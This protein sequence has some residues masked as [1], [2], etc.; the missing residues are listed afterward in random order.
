[1]CKVLIHKIF[2]S[3][4]PLLYSLDLYSQDTKAMAMSDS[5]FAVGVELY[6]QERYE[7]SAVIF[8]ELLGI[9]TL[10]W[11]EVR[12]QRMVYT[13]MWLGSALYKIGKE[14]EA[15][16]ETLTSLYYKADPVDHRNMLK[17]DSLST[18]ARA[19]IRN[20]E[21]DEAIRLFSE[22]RKIVDSVL[23]SDHIWAV[24]NRLELAKIYQLKID[25]ALEKDLEDFRK[26]VF[27][28]F[29]TKSAI[30]NAGMADSLYNVYI[31]G[32]SEYYGETSFPYIIC[33]VTSGD[34]YKR[35]KYSISN[36]WINNVEKGLNLLCRYY[37]QEESWI[38]Q[39]KYNLSEAL[40][41]YAE[42][43][44]NFEMDLLTVTRDE[45]RRKNL[46]LDSVYT[47]SA[48][49]AEDVL[50]IMKD[51]YPHDPFI[52]YVYSLLEKI[53]RNRVNIDGVNLFQDLNPQFYDTSADGLDVSQKEV[54]DMN[55][56][57]LAEL[58]AAALIGADSSSVN[59]WEDK[60]LSLIKDRLEW[61]EHED[62]DEKWEKIYFALEDIIE[63]QNKKKQFSDNILYVQKLM[64][65]DS[66]DLYELL[67]VF[68]LDIASE[69]YEKNGDLEKA[70]EYQIEYY[71]SL[72]YETDAGDKKKSL[73]KIISLGVQSN[74]AIAFFDLRHLLDEFKR[75]ENSPEVNFQK[76]EYDLLVTNLLDIYQKNKDSN[77]AQLIE[78]LLLKCIE[79]N[80]DDDKIPFFN[81]LVDFYESNNRKN[82]AVK[83]RYD[84]FA[85]KANRIRR[86]FLLAN[87]SL[88]NYLWRY[89]RSSMFDI[90][91][92]NMEDSLC[93]PLVY[94][95]ALLTK[96][97][98]L[99]QEM[100]IRE[101]FNKYKNED[102]E[103]AALFDQ[104]QD[105]FNRGE[106]NV[107]LERKLLSKVSKSEYN[108]FL[109][110]KWSDVLKNIKADEVAI[111]FV[112]FPPKIGDGTSRY[113]ASVI[114][115]TFEIPVVVYLFDSEELSEIK[116]YYSDKTLSLKI[117]GRISDYL[118]DVENIYFSADGE[119]HNI[120]IEQLPNWNTIGYVSDTYNF[121]RLSSTRE[122]AL[123]KDKDKIRMAAVYG[124]LRYDAD[125]QVLIADNKKYPAKRDLEVFPIADSLNLR[126]G[127]QELPA[128][129]MEA[130]GIDSALVKV[131]VANKL[132][133]DTL[134]TEA[135]FK[136][137]SGQKC[138][139]LHIATHG[140]YWTEREAQ[141]M[142]HLG[143]LSFG[144]DNQPRY[145]EDKAM[146]RSGLLFAG[147]NHALMGK[148]LPEGVDDGILTAKEISALDLRGLDMVVLSACQTGL[149]EITGDGVFGLQ[150]GFKKAGANTLLMSLWKVDDDAT[151]MLMTQFYANLTTGKSKFDSLREAQHYVREYEVEVAESDSRTAY[152]R[153]K[154][155]RNNEEEESSRPEPTIR[156]VKPYASPRYWAA[157]I[158]LDAVN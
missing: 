3:V 131:K 126:S 28:V 106:S 6:N 43:Y 80:S 69:V 19:Y 109:N 154:S 29:D 82:E 4:F 58:V 44:G 74:G 140:F 40:Y 116:N 9:D 97:T 20:K 88:R 98:L 63:A 105:L 143:F 104:W 117:W 17:A 122:L 11:K 31:E 95:V 99:S 2:L 26:N 52:L 27:S 36:Q 59:P 114:K 153:Y 47:K 130:I 24:N 30:H 113:Y 37:P 138:N 119:L 85:C 156:K 35:S 83:F 87:A 110:I 61:L 39:S 118:E 78:Y 55:M 144:N 16:K 149:G 103:F 5:L 123:A 15:Q 107:E 92:F 10:I 147:A 84:L 68:R 34:F 94:D 66:T 135:S 96:G 141:S 125:E 23:T 155:E 91:R 60:V 112:M 67:N 148:P 12:P 50:E 120:A 7:E 32:L 46:K 102:G 51:K 72:Q 90:I 75:L 81:L 158:L 54:S 21:Y 25:L 64:A 157:F 89:E 133:V 14:D 49:Y 137:L 128:T 57:G 142:D 86:Q 71:N 41:G 38:V 45:Y 127:V 111:E 18:L 62:V 56:V 101:M 33:L 134:G 150:R 13:G 100:A 65:I 77:I 151:R 76:E 53:Y 1:M 79:I 136:A 8:T 70:L 145:V 132:Y 121:Y 152:Q 115:Q 124:G 129:K 73:I 146:T 42:N 139:L 22:R 48:F 108:E 93:T